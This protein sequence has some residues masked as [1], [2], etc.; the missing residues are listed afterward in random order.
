MKIFC[1]V[2]F[3]S[4][5][6]IM[7]ALGEPSRAT[8]QGTLAIKG[9]VLFLNGKEVKPKIEGDFS[10]SIEFNQAFKNGNAILTMNNS[11]GTACPVQYRWLLVTQNDIKQTA[12]FGTCSDLAKPK[13]NGEKIYITLPN[14]SD[15]KKSTYI[16]D[17]SNLT[18][19][20]KQLR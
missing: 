8:P 20:G 2:I 1:A 16:F 10:L 15:S 14:Y 12:E 5:F 3:G 18:E 4:F 11:G 17:G 6:F 19:N 7:P 13:I 9:N